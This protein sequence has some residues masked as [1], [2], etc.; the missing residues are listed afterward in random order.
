MALFPSLTTLYLHANKIGKLGEIRKL[1]PMQSLK[2]LSL[3]GNPVEE[4]KHYRNFVLYIC[5][6]LMQFDMSPVTKSELQRVREN[7]CE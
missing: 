1:L 4:N 6:N 2:S 5:P 7:S 3:Y